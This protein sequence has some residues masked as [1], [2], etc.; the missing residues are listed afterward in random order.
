M[1]MRGPLRGL[2]GVVGLHGFVLLMVGMAVA[3]VVTLLCASA[4]PRP[5]VAG[6]IVVATAIFTLAPPL[7][8]SDVF[9]YIAYG[10]LGMHGINPYAHGPA[11]LMTDPV[12][13]YTGHLWKRDPSAYGPLFTLISQALAPLGTAGALWAMKLIAGLSSLGCAAL[14]WLIAKRLDKSPAFA[15]AGTVRPPS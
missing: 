15:A 5:L 2:G 13:P 4:L 3:W 9:N 11:A 7:L 1:W 6:T 8:S 14:V 12:Y 10:R